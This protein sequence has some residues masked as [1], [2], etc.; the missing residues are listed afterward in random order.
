MQA[1]EFVEPE[2]A[3][4]AFTGSIRLDPGGWVELKKDTL[5]GEYPTTGDH[6]VIGP[7]FQ[8]KAVRQWLGFEAEIEHVDDG[9]VAQLTGDGFRLHDGIS[10]Y[11]WDGAAWVVNTVNWNTQAEVAA[12]I[13]TFPAVARKIRAVIRLT[14]TDKR[15]TPKLRWAKVA[16]KGKVFWLEDIIYR[17]LVPYLRNIN[18]IVDIAFPV[19]FPGGT[20]L[21]VGAALDGIGIPFTVVDVDAVFNHATDIDAYTNLL[22][23]YNTSTRIATLSVAIPVGTVAKVRLV[24]RP[25]IVV[26]STS[27]E[28]SEV[29]KVPALVITDI[30]EVGSSPLSQEDG[31]VNRATGAA[32]RVPAPYRFDVR[33][34]MIALAA[35]GVDLSRMIG[36]IV[37]YL[38]NNPLLRATATD[39]T[40]RVHLVDEFTTR[41]RPELN[42]MH[43]AQATFQIK[44][45]LAFTKPAVSETAVRTLKFGGDLDLDIT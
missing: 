5:T 4:L 28:Y 18:P 26:E 19:A 21:D 27:Q 41:T 45:V 34:T 2:R 25:E 10:Q 35:G 14:T 42:D 13:G 30:D 6:Y 11:W 32:I 31:V 17:S 12:N 44:D 24:V 37:K 22:V 40:H 33:F 38:D 39:R 29:E 36:E 15:Y 1:W 8:P 16:W 7:L 23:S 20:S 9:T 3:N 43:S